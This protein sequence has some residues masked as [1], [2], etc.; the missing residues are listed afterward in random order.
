M[1][2]QNRSFQQIGFLI[3]LVFW[4]EWDINGLESMIFEVS[5]LML[6]VIA[7]ETALA[8]AISTKSV[9]VITAHSHNPHRFAS[10]GDDNIVRIWDLRRVNEP[11]IFFAS[12]FRFPIYPSSPNIPFINCRGVPFN[13][14][15]WVSHL[16]TVP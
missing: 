13:K 10:F 11:V 4:L 6:I 8:T 12:C 16:K 14:M 2:R 7:P 9:Q 5:L 15:L 3:H 1:A